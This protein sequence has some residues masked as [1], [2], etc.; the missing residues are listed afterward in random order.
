MSQTTPV[1]VNVP[2]SLYNSCGL[3]LLNLR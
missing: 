2:P 1:V 3:A